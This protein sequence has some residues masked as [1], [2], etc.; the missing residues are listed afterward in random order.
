MSRPAPKLKLVTFGQALGLGHGFIIALTKQRF[1]TV[2]RP[3][4]PTE[5]AR[6]FAIPPSG[7][8]LKGAVCDKVL[9][10]MTKSPDLHQTE[11]RNV[12]RGLRFHFRAPKKARRK[13][14][15]FRSGKR[16]AKYN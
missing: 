14:G 16:G 2:K 3:S 4:F 6:Y 9:G 11:I 7:G 13:A 15:Q 10:S 5:K 1:E 8:R 12:L